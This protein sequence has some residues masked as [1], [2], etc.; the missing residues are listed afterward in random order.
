MSLLRFTDIQQSLWDLAD[1][2][3]LREIIPQASQFDQSG[4]FPRPIFDAAQKA[5]LLNLTLPENY[6]GAGLGVTEHCI[7]TER[8]ARG[9]VG[10][11]GALSLNG[12]F[13]DGLLLA[14]TEEQRKK[15]F[16]RILEGGVAGYAM[17]EPAAGSD[18]VGIQTRAEKKGA[19][20]ILNGS[21]T[22][23]S[24]ATEASVFL[25]FAKTDPQAGHKGMS[26]FI[27]EKDF[28]GM[29]I[30]KKLE[31]LGQRAFPA[32]ELFFEDLQVPAQNLLGKEGEGFKIAM[33]IFDRSRP[34]VAALAVGLLQRCLDESLNYAKVRK[35]GGRLLLEHQAIG[36]K[37]SD[38]KIKLDAA[39]LLT[40]QSSFLVDNKEPNTLAASEAKA[41]A[42]DSASWAASEAVQIFGGM[43]YSTEY[44]VEKLYRDAKVLQIYEGTSEIQRNIILREITK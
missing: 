44:P 37:L 35:S 31:K 21:K 1:Q 12:M 8:F 22:W 20:Y 2:F 36:H 38:M 28:P 19:S 26:C 29:R 6:G 34:M 32:A 27:V 25:V 11:T 16:P 42:A 14:G 40:Y 10:I 3:C 9:C 30:G 41:F 23:I 5:G 15:Y 43:G 24:N 4:K 17:T 18:V 7:V 13:F 39:R 33:Q